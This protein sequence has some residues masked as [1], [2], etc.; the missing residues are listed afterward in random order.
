[1]QPHLPVFVAST[2]SLL[3][4]SPGV[5]QAARVGARNVTALEAETCS[6]E[7]EAVTGL[8]IR[9]T[10]AN[11]LKGFSLAVY[12]GSDDA[13]SRHVL[14]T[15]AWTGSRCEQTLEAAAHTLGRTPRAWRRCLSP[16]CHE[17]V[18]VD[19]GANVGWWT[20]SAAA[21]GW[22]VVAVEG[23]PTNVA[24]L[25]LSLCLNPELAPLV[26]VHHALVGGGTAARERACAIATDTAHQGDGHV[27]CNLHGRPVDWTPDQLLEYAGAGGDAIGG[28]RAFRVPLRRLSEILD[29]AWER[30]AKTP[31]HA[32][33][34]KLDVE[35]SE[36]AALN[37]TL[38]WLKKGR[39]PVVYSEVWR[40]GGGGQGGV[41]G[42][43]RMLRANGYAVCV[44]RAG[45][46]SERIPVP[47]QQIYRSGTGPV[48]IPTALQ[49]TSTS[50]P[51]RGRWRPS[52]RLYVKSGYLLP[53]NRP[54][55]T[56]VHS[57]HDSICW[58]DLRGTVLTRRCP[59][60]GE[61]KQVNRI[62]LF[63]FSQ[64]TRLEKKKKNT[65]KANTTSCTPQTPRFPFAAQ[66][67]KRREDT[68]HIRCNPAIHALLRW[69]CGGGSGCVWVA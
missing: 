64:Y 45:G 29:D 49:R 16:P 39:L 65:K 30:D 37:G 57:A 61:T 8:G 24:L 14:R 32:T 59:K 67:Y 31:H 27:A 13:L 18:A 36:Y 66:K 48:R 4:F 3:A 68:T 12:R 44:G 60:V 5:C 11:T 52:Q 26:E 53:L 25:R 1:M 62:H 54:A 21:K 69:A 47:Q 35:G 46:K 51:L 42:L 43:L 22:K 55:H 20:F 23:L 33:L 41:V 10:V 19:V 56:H 58:R 50:P 2:L 15:G 34:L 28:R 38:R 7:L 63:T 9:Y 40:R 6:E 17:H